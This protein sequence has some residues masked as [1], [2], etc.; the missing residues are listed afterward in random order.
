MNNS[1][2]ISNIDNFPKFQQN[3][4]NPWSNIV[5]NS[6]N[7]ANDSVKDTIAKTGCGPVSLAILVSGLLKDLDVISNVKKILRSE[8]FEYNSQRSNEYH[9]KLLNDESNQLTPDEAIAMATLTNSKPDGIGVGSDDGIFSNVVEKYFVEHLSVSEIKPTELL[10]TL[11]QGHVVVAHSNAVDRG[12]E[13]QRNSFFTRCGHYF[14][15]V[16]MEIIEGK[17]YVVVNDPD[18]EIYDNEY[19]EEGDLVL[20]NRYRL[21]SVIHP[22]KGSCDKFWIISKK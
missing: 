20:N 5:Y 16:G 9:I 12:T 17:P 21:D 13:K 6:Y 22:L 7:N 15:I 19:F 11:K 3:G 10:K 14:A 4:E 18:E 2:S 1:R 8:V